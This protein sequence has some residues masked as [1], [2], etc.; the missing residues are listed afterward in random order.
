M[1]IIKYILISILINIY[2][3]EEQN[4]SPPKIEKDLKCGKS[5][6]G[7]PNDEKDCIK[8][9]TGSGMLCWFVADSPNDNKNGECYLVPYSLAEGAGING[10]KTFTTL[11]EGEKPYWSCGNKSYFLNTDII[12]IFVFIFLM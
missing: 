8:Y 7:H 10:E 12:M 1:S 9:G 2:L 11:G 4:Q 5:I 6:N 3:S